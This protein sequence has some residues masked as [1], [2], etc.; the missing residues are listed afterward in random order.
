MIGSHNSDIDLSFYNDRVKEVI[1]AGIIAEPFTYVPI[2]AGHME[3]VGGNALVF[4]K[5]T[6]GYDIINPSVAIDISYTDVALLKPRFDLVIE[7]VMIGKTPPIS[8]PTTFEWMG[9]HAY[10]YGE[11]VSYGG[12]NFYRCVTSSQYGTL[13]NPVGS[14]QWET[15]NP[16]QLFSIRTIS[17]VVVITLPQTVY[18]G[19]YY[20]ITAEN[21]AKGITS[22][23][24]S[25]EA[26]PA[27]TVADVKAG[28]EL[29]LANKGFVVGAGAYDWEIYLYPDHAHFQQSP[30]YEH[31]DI[32]DVYKDYTFEAYILALGF[33][34]KYP[35]LKCGATH[36]WGIVY[37]DRANRTCSVMK[38]DG[39]TT[40][41]PFYSEESDNLLSSII[42]LTFE[43]YHKPPVDKDGI[44]WAKTYEIVYFGNISMDYFIQIRADDITALAFGSNRFSLNINLTYEHIW[45]ENNRWHVDP[46]TWIPGD[47]LRLIGYID[48]VT[49]VVTK[50]NTLYDYEIEETGTQYGDTIGGEWL[51]F[52]AV[53]HPVTFAGAVNIIVEIYRPVKGLKSTTPYGTGM[54]FDIEVDEFGNYY[55]KGDIDQVFDEAGACTVVAEVENTANDSWKYIRLNYEHGSADIL[56]FWAESIFPSDWWNE[57]DINLKLTSNGFPFLEDLSQR[58]TELDERFRFGG[59][60]ISG[61]RTN[62]IAHFTYLNYRDLQKKNGDIIGLREVGFTLK[63]IQMYK[64]TS[65]YINRVQSFNPDGTSQFILTDTFIGDIRPMEDD[66]GC[67]HPDSIMVNGRN[68]YYW[69][70][71]QGVFIRSAPNGQIALSGPEYKMSRW[72]KDLTKW[73]KTSG[74]S[75]LLVVNTGANNDFDEI[76]IT[77]RMGTEIKGLIFSEKRGRFISEINQITESYIHLGNFFAHLYH[78]RLWIMNIDEGQDWLSWVG[79]P[80]Y[81]ELEVVSN[82]EPSK[83]KVY[84]AIAVI[85]DHLMQSLA[86]YVNI[87][88]EASGAGELMESNVPIFDRRE[89]VYFGKIMKDENSKGT[90][91]LLSKKLNGRDLRGRFCFVKL[92]TEEHDEKVRVDS[93]VVFST[94]SE[95]NI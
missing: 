69:D 9:G 61:T 14:N 53:D 42:N 93:V 82:A 79:V 45:N 18:V 24:A 13:A 32:I 16:Q 73:I 43:I 57:Q 22:R 77:F 71:S 4:G 11:V 80:T 21:L 17:G 19:A 47:R 85:T 2:K 35:H 3:L 46:Y 70:N 48:A 81:A 60:L 64:E 39:M 90:A 63:A 10:Y 49:G 92:R 12:V 88:I 5:I 84:N 33:T 34:M 83:N 66:Y 76:W 59:A 62:N 94:L 55:H 50:Y 23:T 89:G 37:K 54:V 40:Y 78:Q 56:E 29:D 74:G 27:D 38:T 30:Y 20:T 15:V 67:Q 95:R 7:K 68:V 91:T 25:Y 86:K 1:D 28:L 8:F 31:G 44:C 72:F 41:I 36:A 51:I 75:K 6:E 65:I 58:Q 87:P 26:Q 52:Q